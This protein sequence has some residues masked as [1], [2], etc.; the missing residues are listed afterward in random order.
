MRPVQNILDWDRSNPST[1][2][3]SQA[4]GIM[5]QKCWDQ[6]TSSLALIKPK[7]SNKFPC[8]R[9]YYISGDIT[10]DTGASWEDDTNIIR[11]SQMSTRSES[12]SGAFWHLARLTKLPST[13]CALGPRGHSALTVIFA[14]G[15]SWWDGILAY[16]QLSSKN[17]STRTKR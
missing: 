6:L 12:T 16:N 10:Q 4:P 9:P 3:H 1:K 5:K 7:T 13:H 15:S 17:G 8:V 2:S 11:G 14:R